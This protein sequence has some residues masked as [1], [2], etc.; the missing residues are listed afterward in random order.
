MLC[1]AFVLFVS[2]CWAL[3][4][5]PHLFPASGTE[6]CV[7]GSHLQVGMYNQTTNK[8][9]VDMA[10]VPEVQYDW[11]ADY[12]KWCGQWDTGVQPD[13]ANADGI[14]F[15][16]AS[17]CADNFCYVDINNCDANPIASSVFPGVE[18]IYFSIDTCVG[19]GT[20]TVGCPCLNSNAMVT[21]PNMLTDG[22]STSGTAVLKFTVPGK[23]V[24][25]AL[26]ILEQLAIETGFTY[27]V[28]VLGSPGACT[29]AYYETVGGEC[30]PTFGPFFNKLMNRFDIAGPW[31]MKTS[32]RELNH[33]FAPSYIDNSITLITVTHSI[34]VGI[35]WLS[36]AAPFTGSAWLLIMAMCILTGIATFMFEKG[37]HFKDKFSDVER[38]LATAIEEALE[39]LV[40]GGSV[41]EATTTAGKLASVSFTFVILVIIAGTCVSLPPNG[42]HDTEPVRPRSIHLTVLQ[43]TR[44]TR[45][46]F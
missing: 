26:D 43:L 32:E 1:V 44:R 22:V 29:Q 17:W 10:K 34:D 12:G 7:K 9:L 38:G 8:Q 30:P 46:L 40:I 36:W 42:S 16:P 37:V 45:L 15:N 24:G 35:D 39:G 4:S 21:G 19:G 28:F 41:Q 5:Q 33:D 18:G 2:Q 27:D 31:W 11:S 25:M 20:G 23:P 14:P 3:I 13:C 6:Y